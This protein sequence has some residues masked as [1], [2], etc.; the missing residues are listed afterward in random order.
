MRWRNVLAAMSAGLV[1]APLGAATG[2][3]GGGPRPGAPGLG[4]PYFPTY[5]N[6][7]YDV[8]HY[9][10]DIRYQPDSD[11]LTGRVVIRARA[12]RHLSSFNLDFVGLTI[13]RLRVDGRTAAHSRD[14]QELTVH[15]TLVKGSA[16]TV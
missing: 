6:G 12:T 16:F 2:V 11:L 15:R 13:D 1:L 9:D 3:A 14:G 8:V 10:L 4:D 5:G 7:G